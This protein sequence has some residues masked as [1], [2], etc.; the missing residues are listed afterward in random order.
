[1]HGAPCPVAVASP[2]TDHHARL[3]RQVGVGVD[4]GPEARAAL[5]FAV[6]LTREREATLRV[7]TA[8]SAPVAFSPA[9]AYSYDWSGLLE[10]DRRAAR[11]RLEELTAGLDVPVIV[12]VETGSAD[13]QLEQLSKAVDVLVVGSRGWGAFRRVVLG[14]TSDHLVHHAACPVI[15]V[16]APGD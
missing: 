6:A 2:G 3:I 9:Y 4:D 16:P 14:S 1:M 12:D 7:L 13:E 11:E 8:V 10:E 5:D 15:V